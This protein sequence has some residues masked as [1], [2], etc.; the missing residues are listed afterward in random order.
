M[1]YIVCIKQVP[2]TTKV[3]IDNRTNSLLR[4]GVPSIMNPYDKHALESALALKDNNGGK[5]TILSMGPPQAEECLRDGLAMGAD[6]AVLLCDEAFRGADTL[7]TAYTLAAAIRCL[8]PFRLILCGKQ[9]VDGDTAQV[10]PEIAEMLGIPQLTGVNGLRLEGD[11]IIAERELESGGLEVE[12]ALPALVTVTRKV[13]EP[14]LPT[15]PG[16]LKANRAAI[17]RWGK[18]DLGLDSARIGWNGSPTQVRRIFYPDHE[19]RG[20]IHR[21]SAE[22]LSSWLFGELADKGF[23]R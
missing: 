16:R 12:A 2:D 14:R 5:V 23:I 8:A 9:A 22:E 10:G 21:G 17:P 4:E 18:N 7:A 19:R 20:K 11:K 13:N 15:V 1:R 6:D 3:A